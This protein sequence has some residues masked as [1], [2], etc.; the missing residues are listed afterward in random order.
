MA[1][2]LEKDPYKV[3]TTLHYR[4][5]EASQKNRLEKLA[6]AVNFVWNFCNETS[7]NAIRNH[8]RFLSENDL[9]N[10]TA[11]SSKELGI[12]SV[13]IQGICEEYVLRRTQFKKIKLRWRA[14]QGARK[15]LGWIPFK[16]NAIQV[17]GD[18][19]SYLGHRYR[20][21]LSRPIEG[22]VLSGSFSQDAKGHWYVNLAC[23][24]SKK[25][26]RQTVEEVGIDLGLK[27]S[28]VLSDGTVIEN[29]A[30][31]RKLEEKLGK[32]QR[33]HK[34]K[35]VKKLHT[36]I[37]N[38]RQDFFHKETTRIVQKYSAIFVGNVSGKFVQ[39]SNGKSSADASI[40]VIRNFLRYKA[41][42]H[43]GSFYEVSESS[44]TVTCSSCHQKTGP[45]G[46]RDLGVREWTCSSC[47]SH[48]DRDINAARNILRF[49]RESLRVTK[50]A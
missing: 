48:H 25:E 17:K 32:A 35:Q 9:K 13:T 18:Q 22:R 2:R 23:E 11:G 46:L 26:P 14:S 5:K 4:L 33:A 19:I 7:F 50:V 6:C 43:S 20:L 45:S 44:S 37:K 36:K 40:G 31:Y 3:V 15:S 30:E 29:R 16:A 47:N 28:A 41:I 10:L 24:V 21:W 39:S 1:Q 27:T 49:G 8:S 38:K 12:S 42:R 34:K